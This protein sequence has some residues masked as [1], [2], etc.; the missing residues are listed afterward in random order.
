MKKD[1]QQDWKDKVVVDN[2]HFFVNTK[3]KNSQQT[4][5]YKGIT[6]GDE[7]KKLGFQLGAKKLKNL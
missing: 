3:P 4:D 7:T 1:E 2:A 5:K 6:N